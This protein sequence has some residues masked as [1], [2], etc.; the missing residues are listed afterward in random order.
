MQHYDMLRTGQNT[1]ETALTPTNVNATTFGKLFALSV[2]GQVYA[3]PLYMPNVTV[4]G[5]GSHNVVYVAT[6]NDSLYAF[7]GDIGGAPLWMITLL[8]NGGTAVPNTD[9]VAGDINPE[10]GVT[11]TPVIDPSSGTLYVVAK[12]LEN[13]NFVQRLHAIDITSGAEKFGGPVVLQPS[14]PGTGSGSTTGTLPFSSQWENQRPGLLLLNGYVYV[15]FAS[16][17][18]NGPWHGW[19]LSFN[20]STLQAAG[21][22]C[23]SPNG[24]GGGIWGAG[25]GLAAD[26][27]GTGRIFVSTGN[28]DYPATGNVVP[29]P[30]PAPSASV[31]FGDSIV[32]LTTSSTGQITPTDYFTPYNSASLDSGDTDL[33]S[34]GVLIPPN[35]GGPYPHILIEVGKQGRIYVINR[36]A[37]TSD[38]SHHC[39]NCS[40]DPEII[41]TVNGNGGL[42]GAPA[43]WNGNVYFLGTSDYLRA[44]SLSNGLLSTSPKSESANITNYPGSTPVISANG[45]TNGIVW[46]VDSSG[47]ATQTPSVLRAFDATDVANLFYDSSLTDGRDTLGA[48]V[49]F[50]TPAVVNGKVYVGTRTEVDVFGLLNDLPQAA[51]PTFSIPGGSYPGS[52][53]VVLSTTTPN[54][55]IYYTTDGTTPTTNS[56]LYQTSIPVIATMTVNAI[57][58]ATGYL[59][60]PIAT[61]TYTIAAGTAAPDLSP[62]PGTYTTTQSVQLSD[63]TANATIYYTTNG[64][65]PTRNSSVYSAP[66]TVSTTTT[67]NSIAS[68]AGLADSGVSAGTYTINTNGTTSINFGSGF[69]IPTGMQFN[70]NTDLDDSRLQLTNGQPNEAGSAFFTTPMDIRNFTTDFTFQLSDAMA[71]GITFTIQDS[72]AGA[73]ALGA[74]GGSLGYGGATKILN[75]VAIKFDIYNNSGEGDDSTGL[76]TDGANPTLP[77]TDI[78]ASGIELDNGDTIAAH[79][80][81]NGTTLTMTLTDAVI[82]KTYTISWPVNIPATVGANTAYVGFTGGSGGLTASQKIESWTFVS[83]PP[84]AATPQIAPGTETFTGSISVMLTDATGGAA[85]YYTTDGSVPNPGVGTTKLYSTA[86]NVSATETVN[87]IAT[88]AGDA[89]SS[90]ATATFTLQQAAAP[91]FSPAAGAIASTQAITI[92]DTTVNPV[93]YYTTDGST[94]APGVGTTKQYSAALAL[95]SSA[96]VNA[97]A[98]ASGYAN[99]AMASATYTIATQ[100]QTPAPVFSPV[101]G[102]YTSTQSVQLTDPGATIYYTTNGTTPTH[103]SLVYSGPITVATTTT[104]NAIASEAGMADSGVGAATYTINTGGTT[105]I[106]FA[107]GFSSSTGMQFNGSTSLNGTALELTNGGANEAGSAFFSTPMNIQSFTTDFVFQLSNAKADGMTF[108]IQNSSAGVTALGAIGGSLG[109]GGTTKILNSVA[110]KFDIYNNSG[111]GNDSTGLYTDGANP[112][113]PAVDITSSGIVFSSGDA[114]AAHITYDGTTLTMTLA[115]KVTGKTYTDSWAINIPSTVGGNTAYVGF[116]GGSGGS[117]AIQNVETWTFA[118]IPPGAVNF[119]SGFT[120]TTGLQLNGSATWNQ[121]AN[122]LT[123]TNGGSNEASS[124]F[125]TTPV[126]VQ[127]FTNDFSFQLTNPVADG[128]TFT[129]QNAGPTAVGTVGGSLGY[130]PAMGASIAVK[131][132]LYSNSGEGS[133]STGEYSGGA[134]PTVPAIDMTNSGLNLH[135]GDVMNVQMNYDGTILSMTIA[136]A[137]AGTSFSTSWTVNIPSLVGAST[138]Y[139]GFTAGTGG[140]SSTQEIISW[141]YTPSTNSI[142]Y[143]TENLL[144]STVTSGPRYIAFAWT[145][146]TNGNGTELESTKVG[147]NVAITL[148]VPTAGTYDVKYAVKMYNDRGIAQLAVNGANLGPTEDQYAATN[149]WQELDVGTVTLAAG[150]NVFK[151]TV[152]G[153]NAASSGYTLAWDYVKLTPQ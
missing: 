145:G 115:D 143:E 88:L 98:T 12:S 101:T 144:T 10:I 57:A 75:S 112:T 65:M 53:Q 40:S 76:Y 126:S 46:V 60:S 15:G 36:D 41:Q 92:S 16:H 39:N 106:D 79:I 56:Q 83:T 108:T 74:V 120:S 26:T 114:I 38:G 109:Y 71:D 7:D 31:D 93:I 119:S 102:T 61:S 63:T 59:A 27:V 86:F 135:S 134:K 29:N 52:V 49:K 141:S 14:V 107:S 66:I 81:Y 128:F 152:I 11:G 70:G 20:A 87:A 3:Q 111:E 139:V 97:M 23:T 131:F 6:E 89:N 77:A 82:S 138:A 2:D 147:D 51:P 99:S 94:P 80:T 127:K 110:I 30:A 122:R 72:S 55:A 1:A 37:M 5:H 124:A 84:V 67:I 103:G 123:L 95:S 54:G 62:A 69:S 25:S 32:Q 28:G 9:V 100:T 150:N 116:T 136:D 24:I 113:V 91:T 47:Y 73:T 43:Y 129:I 13:G 90:V 125:Y 96:T 44:Y 34:G 149:V 118:S 78:S 130:G 19:V 140:S 148:N 35:Q 22:W 121:A 50:V 17:G 4:S 117:T 132:D 21:A 146:F 151:F 105:A 33:G 48:A 68:A 18:D 58:V 137:T 133:D 142:Q 85:I 8:T 153:K 45:T 64:T 42:W 104:I